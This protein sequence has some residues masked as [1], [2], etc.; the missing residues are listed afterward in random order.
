[1]FPSLPIENEY[2]CWLGM[3]LGIIII[4]IIINMD[5]VCIYCGGSPGSRPYVTLNS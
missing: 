3:A 4:M 1:M 2:I 5:Y